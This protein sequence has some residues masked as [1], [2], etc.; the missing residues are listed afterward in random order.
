M[1]R[2]LLYLLIIAFFVFFIRST[3]AQTGCF[4]YEGSPFYCQEISP[5]QA[6]QECSFSDDCLLSR[7]FLENQR[8][9]MQASCEKILCKSSCQKEFIAR[10]VAGGV[11]VGK[12]QEWCSP[13]CCQIPGSNCEFKGNK[14][15]CEIS[16]LN[17]GKSTF[18]FTPMNQEQCFTH[19]QTPAPLTTVEQVVKASSIISSPP[20]VINQS[21]RNG[22]RTLETR[23]L[24]NNNSE[25]PFLI[26]LLI[27]I[28]L[29]LIFLFYVLL[30]K[31]DLKNKRRFHFTVRREF[32]FPR[33]FSPFSSNPEV[34][35]HLR[36]IREQHDHKSKE[37][38]REYLLAKFGKDTNLKYRVESEEFRRLRHLVKYYGKQQ[39]SL[40]KEEKN[41]FRRLEEVIHP[42]QSPSLGSNG[43][44]MKVQKTTAEERRKIFSRLEQLSSQK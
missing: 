40:T 5:V 23:A 25:S 12:E 35:Q 14:W 30:R 17:S 16:V 29:F 2:G 9:E 31:L 41:L 20:L 26:F 43:K 10:C 21:S 6:D 11:P 44:E 37:N 19:C 1:K 27:F 39:K 3:V 15:L 36:K 22:S 28:A 38:Q 18:Q 4:L 7:V 34:Q 8:C 24:K 33:I 42:Q 32:P 13:G